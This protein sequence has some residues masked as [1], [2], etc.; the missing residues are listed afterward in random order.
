MRNTLKDYGKCALKNRFV[1][2]AVASIG[3]GSLIYYGGNE[4]GINNSALNSVVF[5]LDFLGLCSL[6]QTFFGLPTY[7]TY[8]RTANHIRRNNGLDSNFK[9]VVQEYPYCLKVGA[10]LAIKEAG[11]ESHL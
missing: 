2:G 9:K 3:L 4:V 11:L 6:G 10:E 8:Q 5:F 7:W 1:S